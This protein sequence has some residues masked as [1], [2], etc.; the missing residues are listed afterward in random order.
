MAH[1]ARP[2]SQVYGQGIMTLFENPAYFSAHGR[3]MS[4]NNHLIRAWLSVS[5]TEHRE[6]GDEE[7]KEKAINRVTSWSNCEEITYVQGQ[8][9]SPS[10]MIGG[11]I[12][13]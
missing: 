8:R 7:V 4:Q 6:E 2:I 5:F 13:I 1:C 10:K 3:L 9:R 11:R 12:H